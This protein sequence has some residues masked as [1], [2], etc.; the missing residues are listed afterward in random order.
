MLMHSPNL[1]IVL[2]GLSG[3]GK[4]T[5]G[6]LLAERMCAE[7]CKTPHQL[8]EPFRKVIDSGADPNA[9]LLFYLA[10]IFQS[11][12]E[13]SRMLQ[14]R[15][16]VCDRFVFTTLYYH[17]ALGATLEIPDSFLVRLANPDYTFLIVRDEQKRMRYLSV[18]HP[19]YETPRRKTID[20][21]LLAGYRKHG[22]P[23]IDNSKDNP[24]AAVEQILRHIDG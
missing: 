12:A 23:E 4:T 13:I 2:E 11:S 9:S 1:F 10:G 24:I 8:F 14:S 19:D 5:I 6:K 18:S 17:K 21:T 22:L 3:T 16:V 15:S 7:Y 20:Q